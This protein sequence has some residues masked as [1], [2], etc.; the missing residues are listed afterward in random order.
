MDPTRWLHQT[1]AYKTKGAPDVNGDATPSALITVAARVQE[2][3]Y[4]IRTSD[5]TER[6]ASARIYTASEIPMGSQVWLPG[7]DTSD[8]SKAREALSR[9]ESTRLHDTATTLAVTMLG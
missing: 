5:G 9:G 7:E 6:V 1:V 4:V 8:V 2:G 3:E